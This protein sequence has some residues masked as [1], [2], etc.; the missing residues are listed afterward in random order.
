[1]PSEI[2]SSFVA[3]EITGDDHTLNFVGA[4][5]DL[6]DLSVTHIAFSRIVNGV[7]VTTKDLDSISRN[8]HGNV[9]SK[10]LSHSS[11]CRVRFAFVLQV[12][13]TINEQTG[14]FDLHGHISH[15]EAQ[16]LEFANAAAEL[17]T[18]LGVFHSSVEGALCDT[19][20]LRGNAD[21]AAVQGLHSNLEAFAF[22]AEQIFFRN[23]AVFKINSAV[24]EV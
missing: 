23:F 7:A 16:G 8:F 17:F 10:A 6:G 13:C 12:S 5:V 24:R 14:S 21:T 3:Q 20:S 18:F 22:F 9:G 15:L 1:M 19:Q 4:F 2:I 11:G